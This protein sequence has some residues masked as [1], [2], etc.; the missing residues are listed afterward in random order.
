MRPR[1]A[2]FLFPLVPIVLATGA[3]A[4]SPPR[5]VVFEDFM[6]PT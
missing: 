2:L 5:V 4:Q 1:R 3:F 6:D